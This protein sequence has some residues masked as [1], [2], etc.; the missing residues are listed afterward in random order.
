MGNDERRIKTRVFLRYSSFSI[1]SFPNRK[2]VR[3]RCAEH[4]AGRS[5]NGA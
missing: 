4:P 1:Y 2:G 3:R 5:G